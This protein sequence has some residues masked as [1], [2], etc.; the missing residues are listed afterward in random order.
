M[1]GAFK[2]IIKVKPLLSCLNFLL[3]NL[4]FFKKKINRELPRFNRIP[5]QYK[6][7]T[8]IAAYFETA[9]TGFYIFCRAKKL[10][11]SLNS[12]IGSALIVYKSLYYS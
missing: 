2:G 12:P 3:S 8:K 1:E 5:K 6:Q 10:S 11:T 9:E 4:K 7:Q